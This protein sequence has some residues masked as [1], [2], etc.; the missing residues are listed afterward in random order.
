[1]GVPSPGGGAL[2]LVGAGAFG[3]IY[4]QWI[5]ERGGIAIDIGS[6]F[7]SWAN[8]GRVGHPVRSF[9][10]YRQYKRIGRFNAATRYND[11]VD[12]FQLDVPKADVNSDYFQL[13]PEAW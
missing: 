8:I 4:C 12:Y 2:F 7:D 11:L 13:L 1:M 3:K 9:D 10:V 6:I 5:K